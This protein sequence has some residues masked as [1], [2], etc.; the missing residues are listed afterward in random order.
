MRLTSFKVLMS[1]LILIDFFESIQMELS[2]ER[3]NM[4]RIEKLIFLAKAKVFKEVVA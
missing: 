2:Y 3:F 4:T 1:E